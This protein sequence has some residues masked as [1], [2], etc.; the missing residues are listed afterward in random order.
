MAQ[1]FFLAAGGILFFLRV[2]PT[3]GGFGLYLV[4]LNYLPATV[5]ESNRRPRAGPYR[6]SG[7]LP[8]YEQTEPLSNLSEAC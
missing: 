7:I 8:S 1:N 2:G 3:I 5:A 4:T 6:Q